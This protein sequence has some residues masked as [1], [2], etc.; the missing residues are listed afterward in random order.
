MALFAGRDNLAAIQQYA[1]F[2]TQTQRAWLGFPRKKGTS[3]RK[4]PSYSAPCA[5][6]SSE[7]I[8][9]NWPTA[10]IVG[11]RPTSAPFPAPWPSTANGFAIAP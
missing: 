5:T 9:T 10:S 3:F 6:C 4:V 11:S 1:Q 7:S 2:L 8:L